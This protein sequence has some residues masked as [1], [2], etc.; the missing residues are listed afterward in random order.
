MLFGETHVG[1][2]ITPDLCVCVTALDLCVCTIGYAVKVVHSVIRVCLG[3]DV[4]AP[5]RSSSRFNTGC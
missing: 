4:I 1:V 5:T 3:D 2:S